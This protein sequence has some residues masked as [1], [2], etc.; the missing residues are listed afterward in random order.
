MDNPG[1]F[2]GPNLRYVDRL[3][4]EIALL[5][6][7]NLWGAPTHHVM[8]SQKKRKVRKSLESEPEIIDW[9]STENSPKGIA[10]VT[11]IKNQ[12]TCGACW[13]FSICAIV[14]G[15]IAIRYGTLFDLSEQQLVDCAD[16]G[17]CSGGTFPKALNYVESKGLAS[18]VDYPWSSNDGSTGDCQDIPSATQIDSYVKVPSCDEASATTTLRDV[19]PLSVSVSA[20]CP[21]FMYYKSGLFTAGCSST[22][23]DHAVTIVGM[24]TD[25]DENGYQARY[26]VV[27]NSWGASWGIDGYMYLSMEADGVQSSCGVSN[28]L[29]SPIAVHANASKLLTNKSYPPEPSYEDDFYGTIDDDDVHCSQIS[30]WGKKSSHGNDDEY[31]DDGTF[32]PILLFLARSHP[33]WVWVLLLFSMALASFLMCACIRRACSCCCSCFCRE[34]QSSHRRR[35]VRGQRSKYVVMYDESFARVRHRSRPQQHD[36][37]LLHE[38]VFV[39]ATLAPSEYSDE[40]MLYNNYMPPRREAE[41][42]YSIESP[43]PNSHYG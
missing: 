30:I 5:N 43:A 2:L 11:S 26:W 35:Q 37:R 17:G 28:I 19:G 41:E 27:K 3:P 16:N 8:M 38:E 42:N 20:Y 33:A 18:Y 4:D 39:Q 29:E 14:E 25:V 31:D 6:G 40:D 9:R 24:N 7:N 12:G 32:C 1:I 21:E 15:A 22:V 23:N 36:E 13:A 34:S 10:A